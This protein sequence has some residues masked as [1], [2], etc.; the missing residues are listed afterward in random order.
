MPHEAPLGM[1]LTPVPSRSISPGRRRAITALGALACAG[2]VG[3]QSLPTGGVTLI[4]PSPAGGS[5]DALGRVVADALADI[6]E[7]RF[8]VENIS[9]NGGVAGITAM[10]GA[11]RDGSVLGLAVSSALIGGRL[12]SRS[13]TFN[14]SQDFEWL[15]ILGSYANAMVLSTRSNYTT[16]AEWLAFARRTTTP[17]TYATFGTGTAGHLA[18]AYLRYEQRANLTHVTLPFTDEGYAMLSDGRIDVLFDGVPNARV[19]TPRFGH[20]I[21]AVTSP[22]RSPALPDV[23]AFGELFGESFVIWIGLVLPKGVTPAVYVRFASAV[24][25]LLSDPRYAETMRS[26]GLSFMGISGAG[27]RAFIEN[28]FL[29]IAKLIARLNDEGMRR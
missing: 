16:F 12:L 1:Q 7:T 6:M 9:G 19:K 21:V 17:L 26:A 2:S 28:E 5:G 3:A 22:G 10:A 14:A 24:G 25:V 11:P 29:R 13:A 27:T 18:G 15:T 23:P 20:R 8:K 4:V